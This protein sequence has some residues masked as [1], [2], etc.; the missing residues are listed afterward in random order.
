MES[1]DFEK[2]IFHLAYDS[3]KIEFDAAEK[4]YSKSAILISSIAFLGNLTYHLSNPITLISSITE[5]NI[6]I[7][8]PITQLITLILLAITLFFVCRMSLPKAYSTIAAIKMWD[9]W[10]QNQAKQISANNLSLDEEQSQKIHGNFFKEITQKLA[11]SQGK[12]FDINEERRH[13]FSQAI[14]FAIFATMSLCLQG[15]VYF[16]LH[17][18]RLGE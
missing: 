13:Y 17:F 18:Q 14:R 7:L 6:K 5:L 4:F 3:Y 9:D 2:D 8:L 12:N 1:N 10:R 16:A 11:E 15:V